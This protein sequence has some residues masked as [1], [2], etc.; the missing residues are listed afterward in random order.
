MAVE[1]LTRMIIRKPVLQ[2]RFVMQR[3]DEQ[4]RFPI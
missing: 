3:L 1:T 4:I 2:S